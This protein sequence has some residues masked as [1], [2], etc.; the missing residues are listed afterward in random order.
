M[1]TSSIPFLAMMSILL[2]FILSRMSC[3]NPRKQHIVVC[4]IHGHGVWHV[5]DLS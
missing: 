4:C 1:Y 2:G 3:R 5:C